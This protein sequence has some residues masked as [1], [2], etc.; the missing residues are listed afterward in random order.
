MPA[1]L[2]QR[3]DRASMAHS[4]EARV[5]FLSR[6]FVDWALT[7]PTDLKLRK[8]KGKYVLR[9]AVKPWLPAQTPKGRKLGFQMPLADWFVGGFSDFAFEA[10]T[11]SG[12]A[13]AGFLN[14]AEVAKLFEEHRRGQANHGRLLY[15]LAMFS[16]WWKD[17]RVDPRIKIS[18]KGKSVTRAVA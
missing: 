14:S 17:Q 13:D 7:I 11:S 1:S 6:R 10:W 18:N 16:C 15:A 12:A 2:L 4:L 3:L 5:P 8:G 9:E